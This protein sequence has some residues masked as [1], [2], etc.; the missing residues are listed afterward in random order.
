MQLTTTGC[1]LFQIWKLNVTCLQS[2]FHSWCA[3]AL[4]KCLSSLEWSEGIDYRFARLVHLCFCPTFMF[5]ICGN[6][7]VTSLDLCR[8]H[9]LFSHRIALFSSFIDLA[10]ICQLN[11]LRVLG[12]GRECVPSPS[13]LSQV[14]ISRF[15]RCALCS[16]SVHII[17]LECTLSFGLLAEPLRSC[18]FVCLCFAEG[19]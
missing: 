7:K 8:W 2:T 18:R 15:C 12:R 19:I 17:P 11:E 10:F 14:H 6:G 3:S 4:L 9:L 1:L 16:Q 13:P 5:A